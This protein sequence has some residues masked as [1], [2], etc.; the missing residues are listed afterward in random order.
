MGSLKIISQSEKEQVEENRVLIT[1]Y[2]LAELLH[3]D[4]VSEIRK[5]PTQ[6]A[7]RIYTLTAKGK[8]HRATLLIVHI[9]LSH[10]I[11]PWRHHWYYE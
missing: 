7:T 11:A 5:N 9:P 8:A 3:S 2:Q 1:G 6:P 4:S 10:P